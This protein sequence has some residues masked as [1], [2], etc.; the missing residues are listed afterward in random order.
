MTANCLSGEMLSNLIRYFAAYFS[1]KPFEESSDAD[2]SSSAARTET[3]K[4]A[5]KRHTA[6]IVRIRLSMILVSNGRRSNGNTNQQP[7]QRSADVDDHITKCGHPRGNEHL[8]K[9]V[10]RSKKRA[11]QPR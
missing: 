7:Q 4:A 1:G 8:M 11:D 3:P 10:A 9:L 2:S 6:R 5:P